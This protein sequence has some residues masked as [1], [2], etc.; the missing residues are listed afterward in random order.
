MPRAVGVLQVL[1]YYLGAPDGTTQH[2]SAFL[3]LQLQA[4]WP[5]ACVA[6]LGQSLRAA[7]E[8]DRKKRARGPSRD[9][10]SPLRLR[11]ADTRHQPSPPPAAP[12]RPAEAGDGSA[13]L[14]ALAAAGAAGAAEGTVMRSA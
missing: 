10:T 14:V 4:Y 9:G 12:E 6:V 7:A 11:P 13:T 2:T 8:D 1:W 5:D 3:W